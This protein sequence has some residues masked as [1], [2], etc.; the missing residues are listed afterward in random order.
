MPKAKLNVE[1]EEGLFDLY[2]KFYDFYKDGT[3][4]QVVIVKTARDIQDWFYSVNSNLEKGHSK[5]VR[6]YTMVQNFIKV[7]SNCHFF[8]DECPFL[9]VKKG[10]SYY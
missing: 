3:S 6:I 1:E 2:T 8:I 7:H 9:T 4:D 5:E 10:I